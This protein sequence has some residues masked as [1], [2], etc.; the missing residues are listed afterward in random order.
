MN[1]EKLADKYNRE[2][3]VKDILIFSIIY[4]KYNRFIKI[5]LIKI[6]ELMKNYQINE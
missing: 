2:H 3:K 5:S 6:K 1:Y 4:S